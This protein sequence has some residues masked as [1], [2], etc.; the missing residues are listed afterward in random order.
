MQ[1]LFSILACLVACVCAHDALAQAPDCRVELFAA[2]TAHHRGEIVVVPSTPVTLEVHCN[3]TGTP[4]YRWTSGQTTSAIEVQANANG[5]TQDLYGVDV[6]LNGATVTLVARLRTAAAL[7]P[8]CTVSRDPAG[9]VR[10]FTA[11]RITANCT[12]ATSYSWTGGYDLRNQ[13]NTTATHVNVVNEAGT[14]IVDVMGVNVNG[15]GAVVGIPIQYTVAPPSCR[16]LANP[17]GRVTPNASVTLTAEC[18]GNPTSYSWA[19]GATGASVVVN[20]AI[21]ASYTLRAANAAGTGAAAVHTVPVSATQPGLL[22][23]TG[24]W[25]AGTVE[26]GWGMTLNQHGSTIFGVIYFYDAT[27]EP[28]WAV[29]PGGSWNADFSVYTANLYTPTGAPFSSY[30]A[31]LLIPGSPTGEIRLTFASPTVLSAAFRL[32][33]SQFDPNGRSIT[34]FGQKSLTPLVLNSGA[35][36]SGLAVPDMWWGGQSQNGWG[37]SINQ[38]SSELF[39]AWFTYGEDRRPTWFIIT[40]TTWSGNT[41]PASIF[42]VTSSPWLGVPYDATAMQTTSAGQGT[43]SFSDAS[44]AN[45]GYFAS[46]VSGSKTITRQGF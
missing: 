46:G 38:R 19:H 29:M 10:V 33:Y 9:P 17:A 25:W 7:T 14:V 24:H 32:G 26:N 22:N 5:G 31:S 18:D 30:D 16:I 20:P 45:F 3:G 13:G 44:N 6:T 42:R 21:S 4:T 12:N 27:G 36:P 28:T 39:A 23:Y 41:L 40:G 8:V 11:V 35:N 15:P 2:N 37:I 43:L 34:T 1:K